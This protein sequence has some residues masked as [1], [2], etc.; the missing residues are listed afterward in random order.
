MGIS[1][2]LNDFERVAIVCKMR[3][4]KQHH[5]I[6]YECFNYGETLA[7]LPLMKNTSSIIMTIPA[8]YC[9]NFDVELKGRF[10]AWN[11]NIL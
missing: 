8:F 3:H 9:P 11:K 5:N 6:A 7:V 4:V 10:S 1:A 2:S